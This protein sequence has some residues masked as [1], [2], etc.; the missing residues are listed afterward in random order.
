MLLI[1]DNLKKNDL[2]QAQKNLRSAFK[3]TNQDRFNLVILETLKQYIY[4][5]KEKKLITNKK[6]FGNLSIISE[7]FQKCYLADPNT[8]SYFANLINNKDADYTRYIYFYLNYLIENNRANEAKKITDDLELINS[9]LLL[10]Q[11]KSWIES[12][13]EKKLNSFFSCKN[14]NDIISE[15][16][17]LIS[18][19]YSSQNNFE[20]SNF[21][22][23]LSNYLNPKF[24]FNLSLIA[25]NY[26]LNQDYKK[27]KQSIVSII[28]TV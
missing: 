21:Y 7:T 8:D 13:N 27:A 20:K 19:L 28:G 12:E 9:T 16:L 6:N 14:Q 2:D 3:F 10:S 25:E 26:Y 5:F 15:L 24:I 4:V 17:F 18:N 11:A 1:I 23:Y 22:L